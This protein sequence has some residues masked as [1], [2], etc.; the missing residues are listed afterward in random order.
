M[1][2]PSRPR[3]KPSQ[4]S[5]FDSS[6]WFVR[7]PVQGAKKVVQSECTLCRLPIGAATQERATNL[8]EISH[9]VVQHPRSLLQWFLKKRSS[10]AA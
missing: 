7:Q 8:M 4:R 1:N 6:N 9:L 10:R 5:A 3:N 2:G